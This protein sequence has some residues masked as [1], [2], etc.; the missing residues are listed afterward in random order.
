M[1]MMVMMVGGDGDGDGDQ[2]I[3]L[4]FVLD[5]SYV[6]TS[7]H[8]AFALCA[9]PQERRLVGAASV[10]LSDIIVGACV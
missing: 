6:W 1:M 10:L 9:T 8:A 5:S 2:I 4:G 7:A 3:M